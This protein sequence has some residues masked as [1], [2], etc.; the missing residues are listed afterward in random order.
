MLMQL[1]QLV[2]SSLASA[3]LL[4]CSPDVVSVVPHLSLL[5]VVVVLYRPVNCLA[6]LGSSCSSGKL[7]SLFV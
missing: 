4:N 2:M 1:F 6:L 3:D 7:L 5:F